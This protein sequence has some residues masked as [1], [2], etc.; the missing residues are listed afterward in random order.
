[1]ARRAS[2]IGIT[3]R[4]PNGAAFSAAITPA[5]TTI[6][7]MLIMPDGEQHDHQPGAASDAVGAVDDPGTEGRKALVAEQQLERAA[8]APQARPLQRRQPVQPGGGDERP[9][10]APVGEAGV[11][12]GAREHVGGDAVDGPGEEVA[13][14]ET[15]RRAR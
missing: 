15:R 10:C 2:A 1:M 6:Q 12:G 3:S 7:K 11:D 5:I 9:G 8:A 14:H 4:S 13:G